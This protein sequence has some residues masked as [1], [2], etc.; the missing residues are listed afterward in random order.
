MKVRLY[1]YIEADEHNSSR[2]DPKRFLLTF[3][4]ICNSILY[5]SEGKRAHHSNLMHLAGPW[6][7]K[8]LHILS[9]KYLLAQWRVFCPTVQI[10]MTYPAQNLS[11]HCPI[12]VGLLFRVL[13]YGKRVC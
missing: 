11:L 7:Y 4:S 2:K 5:P 12:S 10:S 6:K 13:G 9:L 8:K 1:C 3:Q